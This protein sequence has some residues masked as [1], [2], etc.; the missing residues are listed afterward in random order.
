MFILFQK[1][2]FLQLPHYST[3]AIH[4]PAFLNNFNHCIDPSQ[5]KIIKN[6]AQ[7][8]KFLKSLLMQYFIYN[9]IHDEAS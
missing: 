9:C 5:P 7:K 3:I 4:N 1:F 6:I 2:K 8:T